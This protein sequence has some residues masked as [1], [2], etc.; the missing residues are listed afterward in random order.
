[1]VSELKY[2]SITDTK[3]ELKSKYKKLA[4]KHHPDKNIGKETESTAIMQAINEELAFC[5]RMQGNM[6]GFSASDTETN[7]FTMVNEL[8]NWME[9]LSPEDRRFANSM[10]QTFNTLTRMLNNVNDNI[11]PSKFVKP[12]SNK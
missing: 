8:L 11:S 6:S 4:I 1:M 7:I 2:F 5:M 3:D 10:R 9:T 12:K